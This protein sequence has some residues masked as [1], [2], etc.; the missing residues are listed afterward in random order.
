MSKMSK[1]DMGFRQIHLD[2]HTSP[3][4]GDVGSKFN[5][6]EFAAMAKAAN[7][8]SM[9][10]FAKCH[11]GHL[12]FNTD[13]PARHPSLPRG[14]DLLRGQINALHAAGIRAPI[15]IS[16]E[17]DE[18]SA[19]AHPEWIALAPD[20]GIFGARPLQPG[21][22]CMDMSSPYYEY[23]EQQ[24]IEVLEK[25]DPVD[26]IFFDICCEQE[27]ATKWA[28]AGMDKA[29]LNPDIEADRKAYGRRVGLEYMAKLHRLVT[30][31]CPTASCYFNSRP[32]SLLNHDM[33]YMTHV[34]IEALPTGGWGYMYFPMNVRYVRTFGA[35]YLGMTA[36]FHKS[37]ADFGGLKPEAALKYEISQML[38][39]GAR[40]SVGDQLHP[41]GTLDPVAWGVI[42]R[43]YGHAKDCQPW[44]EDAASAAEVA[45]MRTT[46]AN[47]GYWN[48]VGGTDEGATRMLQ[49]LQHQFDC[50]DPTR[51]LEQYKLVVL[52]DAVAIDAALGKKLDKVLARGGAVLLS[53]RSGLDA[54]RNATWKHLPI[55]GAAE[56]S[57]YHTTFMRP[58][59]ELAGEM[60]DTD[61]VIYEPGLRVKPAAGAKVLATVV[62][63]YFDRTWRHFCSH[64]Q[65][66]PAK[67]TDWP[68]AIQKGKVGYIP[69]PIF[70][71]FG[72]HGAL[73]YRSLVQAC[74]RRLMGPQMVQANLPSGAEVS[75]MT[76]GKA[77]VVHILYWPIERRATNM[78]I[79][80]DTIPLYDVKLSIAVPHKVRRA[81]LAPSKQPLDFT[82]DAGRVELV[83]PK[84]E[85]HQM[86]VLE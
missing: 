34:E 66:P 75:V 12:Y 40:C 33:K 85:G 63:P 62:E 83:V 51:S 45:V 2:F 43:V 9:T 31:R 59:R 50:V 44:C 23:L 29:G 15:Y 55:R 4:I 32:M 49:Q 80:E 48:A 25:F 21:W 10:V 69:Y 28:K 1:V 56:E 36:R 39:H 24:V 7:V 84:I 5:A 70:S 14:M 20:G 30:K 58:A 73:V 22:R 52:P 19:N 46:D 86:V 78:D 47:T 6:K 64:N 17:L 71:L 42:G 13:H 74:I 54:Q 37:W 81:Y 8:D 67:A 11:H 38:A 27:T 53:G 82:L 77:T 16:V 76:R 35:K 65:T 18:F 26:G 41:R 72:V 61:S 3:M 57:P 68:M 79:V 60:L